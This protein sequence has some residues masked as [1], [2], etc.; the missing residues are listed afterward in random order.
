MHALRLF[1]NPVSKHLQLQVY[2]LGAL[3]S[4]TKQ[5]NGF[6]ENVMNTL[7]WATLHI[8]RVVKESLQ[9]MFIRV[10]VIGSN[11]SSKYHFGGS[12]AR[13]G[14]KW[15]PMFDIPPPPP[16]NKHPSNMIRTTLK[17]HDSRLFHIISPV[18]ESHLHS[19][20]VFLPGSIVHVSRTV[21]TLSTLSHLPPSH[22]QTTIVEFNPILGMLQVTLRSNPWRDRSL[23]F[24]ST[25]LRAEP[26]PNDGRFVSSSSPF[27][28]SFLSTLPFIPFPTWDSFH[29]FLLGALVVF[30][31]LSS[32]L[33]PFSTSLFDREHFRQPTLLSTSQN[34][35]HVGPLQSRSPRAAM[36]RSY[37]HRGKPPIPPG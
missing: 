10:S 2:K 23:A 28:S 20:E 12:R 4:E 26:C 3:T 29:S 9:G 13:Y 21:D 34:N 35:Q 32:F 25:P 18:F 11:P 5:P 24:P 31:S 37:R 30:R 22:I 36:L 19:T 16:S 6:A 8:M 27:T 1:N 33:G 15:I 14:H 7:S 17:S